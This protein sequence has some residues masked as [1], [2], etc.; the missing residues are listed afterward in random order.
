MVLLGMIDEAIDGLRASKRSFR[1][2]RTSAGGNVRLARAKRTK[3]QANKSSA[4]L[5]AAT[6]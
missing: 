6:G 1:K 2:R 3:R 5:G 4:I